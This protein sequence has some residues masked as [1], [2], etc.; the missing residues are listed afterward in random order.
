MATPWLRLWADMP[1]DPKWRTIARVSKQSIGNVIAVYVHMMVCAANA[2]ER[3]RTQGWS[4][5]DIG[6]ALDLETDQ[7]TSIRDAMQGRVLDDDYL[8][9]WE[10]R[11]PVREDETASTRAKAW[12]EQQKRLKEQGEQTQPNANEHKITLDTDTDTDNKTPLPPDGGRAKRERKTQTNLQAFLEDCHLKNERPLRG[13][14]PLWEYAKEVGL[15]QDMIAL[16]WAEFKRQFMP[17]G[18]GQAKRQKDWR[19]TFRNYVEKGYLGLWCVDG[20]GQIVLTTKGKLAKKI[21]DGKHD[22]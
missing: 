22:D 4:D 10:R 8:A 14:A 16:A 19:Q 5:E 12:R 3:G 15:D 9:G 13:Y 11:Q 18:V 17:G 6:T 20:N 2:T 1:N 7:I 21:Q